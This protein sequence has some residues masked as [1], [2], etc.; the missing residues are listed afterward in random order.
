M[1]EYHYVHVHTGNGSSAVQLLNDGLRQKIAYFFLWLIC[2]R[3]KMRVTKQESVY[4][5]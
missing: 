1:A 4:N 5:K 3:H 2:F